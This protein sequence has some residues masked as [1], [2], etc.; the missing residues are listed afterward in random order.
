MKLSRFLMAGLVVV[1][2]WTA[3][4]AEAVL[5]LNRNTKVHCADGV[6][7]LTR[8]RQSIKFQPNIK[9]NNEWVPLGMPR[10]EPQFQNPGSYNE[11]ILEYDVPANRT[12]RLSVKTFPNFSGALID[13]RLV[14]DS[15]SNV[16]EY[17]FWSW[18][19]DTTSYVVPEGDLLRRQ[20]FD[21]TKDS[22]LDHAPFVYLPFDRSIGG[23]AMVPNGVIGYQYEPGGNSFLYERAIEHDQ[24]LPPGGYYQNAFGAA[25]VA[26]TEE[27]AA[28]YR[29]VSPYASFGAASSSVA[30]YGKPAPEWLADCRTL[31]GYYRP[32][33]VED[34][35]FWSDEVLDTRL[36]DFSVIIGSQPNAEILERVH[37]RGKKL[38]FYVIYTC[39]LDTKEQ[40]ATGGRVYEEWTESYLNEERDLADHP[41]WVCIDEKGERF[42]DLWGTMHNHMGLF[43]TCLH[44]DG[45]Q[46]AALR[47]VAKLM[48]LGYDGIF[49][50]LAGPTVE[51]YGDKFGIHKHAEPQKTNTDKYYELLDKIYALVKSYGDDRAVI[52]NGPIASNWPRGDALMWEA[53]VFAGGDGKLNQTPSELVLLGKRYS[54]ARKH[55]KMLLPL[56]S[57]PEKN[58]LDNA[59]FSY[60]YAMVFDLC[61]TDYTALWD[62]DRE[63]AE[64]LYALQAGE[65]EGDGSEVHPG[66]WRRDFS[67]GTFFW[68]VARQPVT[69]ELPVQELTPEVVGNGHLASMADGGLK[70][71]IPAMSGC[72]VQK[73]TL[74]SVPEPAGEAA[75]PPAGLPPPAAAPVA[76]DAAAEVIMID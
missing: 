20:Q 69:L 30:D 37:Q 50:D 14:N 70:I 71:T 63:G 18:H 51:C 19:L 72:F 22:T 48:E 34:G 7:E 43:Y 4:A 68:S 60:A 45:V 65:P 38:L 47:Q 21:Q 35:K 73:K 66:V 24:E 44:Q 76:E 53:A 59:M 57:L 16:V 29:Q 28:F 9:H 17:Y 31:A 13:G 11:L 26:D 2:S 52:L 36:K 3:R 6:V 23:L 1:C 49:I 15:E 12:F 62:L 55:G 10:S 8:N 39:F 40:V 42:H 46:E 58:V 67:N 61:W 75:V 64:V 25:L 56:V 5:E 74:E 32:W 41:D 54:E 27:A 33:S